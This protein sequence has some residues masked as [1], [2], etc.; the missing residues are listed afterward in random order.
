[1]KSHVFGRT[2]IRASVL[3]VPY[4][5][6]INLRSLQKLTTQILKVVYWSAL[7]LHMSDRL[8]GFFMSNET[9]TLRVT[10]YLRPPLCPPHAK[11]SV[12][13]PLLSSQTHDPTNPLPFRCSPSNLP[14]K[15]RLRPNGPQ[16]PRRL[17]PPATRDG[18]ADPLP[19][20]EKG[21]RRLQTG[22]D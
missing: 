5:R 8:L 20:A 22:H 17:S 15:L 9:S 11:T 13:T 19:A 4:L 16:H 2:E 10:T 12:R 6:Y 7:V 18:S 3:F 1:M 14:A 21:L